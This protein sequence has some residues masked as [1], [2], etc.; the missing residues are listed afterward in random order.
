[1]SKLKA[2]LSAGEYAILGVLRE[3][4][5]HGYEI[6]RRFAAD[7]DLGL[8]LP[9]DMSTVYALLKELHEQG[10]ID[11]QRETVGLRPPRTVYHLTPEADAQLLH[12]LEE[13]VARLREVRAD[14][15]VKLYFCRAIG[16]AL[17]ARLLDAQLA[18]SRSYLQRAD[19]LA[20]EAAPEGF[21]RL[22]RE[23]KATAARATVAWLAAE[24]D[25]LA[26]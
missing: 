8:V 25:R 12:W 1:M 13:P 19:R 17:A 21:E 24:R 4:P 23:S 14:L 22:V 2:G 7:L 3:R 20:A 6:S 5:M 16:S 9:M 10:L 11:G 18:E 26:G 15:M